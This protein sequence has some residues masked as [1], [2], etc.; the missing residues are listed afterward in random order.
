MIKNI[1]YLPSSTVG[2]RDIFWFY[3]ICRLCKQKTESI[4]RFVPSSSLLTT[5]E[6]KEKHDKIG[7]FIH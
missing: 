6:H 1:S 7:H 5:I 3:A 2:S 4:D